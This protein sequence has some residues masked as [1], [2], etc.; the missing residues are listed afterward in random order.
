MHDAVGWQHVHN[1]LHCP[2]PPAGRAVSTWSYSI[3]PG[4]WCVQNHVLDAVR[5]RS[6]SRRSPCD[7][8]RTRGRSSPKSPERPP[9]LQPAPFHRVDTDVPDGSKGVTSRSEGG[10]EPRF[11]GIHTGDHSY[12]LVGHHRGDTPRRH[13]RVNVA[14][15]DFVCRQYR[16]VP[17]RDAA[18][19]QGTVPR[20]VYGAGNLHGV[21]PL[22]GLVSGLTQ[23]TASPQSPVIGG[24]SRPHEYLTEFTVIM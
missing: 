5:R 14:T 2:R 11:G 20:G 3:G 10:S 13:A 12:H 23:P 24:A 8:R 1:Q 16:D 4:A 15:P 6:C 22:D 18:D 7:Q 19:Q 21:P 17:S 9:T